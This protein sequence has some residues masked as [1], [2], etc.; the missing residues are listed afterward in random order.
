MITRESLFCCKKQ[1]SCPETY[2][3][4]CVICFN[5]LIRFYCVK[6]VPSR[7]DMPKSSQALSAKAASG[8]NRHCAPSN[9]LNTL[10]EDFTLAQQI[11]MKNFTIFC[12]RIPDKILR[13][14]FHRSYSIVS[15]SLH[16]A[17]NTFVIK[18]LT[19]SHIIMPTSRIFKR[20]I[21]ERMLRHI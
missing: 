1:F 18:S 13:F 16:Y 11:A 9:M 19:R 14:S 15:P 5:L 17:H 8:P 20:K 6:S 12:V 3:N 10:I 4:P 21:Y 7:E 2:N